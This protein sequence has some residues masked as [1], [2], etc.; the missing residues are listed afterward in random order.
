LIEERWIEIIEE[1]SFD[2]GARR[3]R[4]PTFSQTLEKWTS[5]TV[6]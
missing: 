4:A 3:F 1:G 5:W 6:Y 2:A